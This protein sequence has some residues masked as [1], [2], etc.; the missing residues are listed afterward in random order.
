MRSLWTCL[1]LL[2]LS[3]CHTYVVRPLN[4]LTTEEILKLSK[5]GVPADQ[6]I[7]KIVESHTAYVMD[8]RDVIQ[9]HEAGVDEKVIN[10]MMETE[11]R[12]R[13]EQAYY[14]HEHYYYDPCCYP[15]HVHWGW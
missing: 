8:A 3:G 11:R 4:P 9:L 5:D 6:I 15:W 10:F 14:H 13:E 12:A 2:F 7:Q 1:C